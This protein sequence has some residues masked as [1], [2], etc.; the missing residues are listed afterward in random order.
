MGRPPL[1]IRLLGRVEIAR[2][3]ESVHLPPS[4]K[5]LTLLAYLALAPTAVTRT[6]LCDL[7]WDVANDPRGELRWCLSKLRALL[8]DDDR[9]R[10]LTTG[11]ELVRLDLS[12]VFVDVHAVD[13]AMKR[14]SPTELQTLFR[15]DFLEGVDPDGGPELA[16]WL[17][18]A[19]QRYRAARPA[20]AIERPEPEPARR[21]A[22]IVI[23]PFADESPGRPLGHGV[24]DDV[25]TR[26]AKLRA[27]FVI[28]R[29]SAYVLRE[30]GVDAQE[31]GRL[32]GVDYVASGRVRVDNGRIAVRVELAETKRAQIV[33]TDD[34][35]AHASETFD[36]LD[37]IV[38]R[39]VAA[40]AEEVEAEECRRAI[41]KPPASL[42]AWEAYHRGL[43]HM[44]RFTPNDNAEAARFFRRALE[45]DATFARAHSG[46][47]FTH[48]QNVFLDLTPDRDVQLAQTFTT[49]AASLGAD[50]RDPTAH[51]A[52]G[53]AL[54]LRGE[55]TESIGVLR[56][57]FDL[58]P[59]FALGHYML[60]F[61]EA[62]L[63]DPSVAIAESNTSRALSPYDPLQFGMLGLRALAHMRRGEHEEAALWAQRAAARP[64]AHAHI[65]AIAA[66]TLALDGRRDDAR[67]LLAR[68]REG[69][70]GYDV[71]AFLRA[72]RFERDAE[73]LLR[74]AAKTFDFG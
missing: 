67:R 7:L 3:G 48:F 46:L 18:A 70:P 66:S 16:A 21:R 14:G 2:A 20:T 61:V 9:K 53:R 27:L 29:G 31:A 34:I 25:I 50:E 32:L 73:R 63:G 38:D 30:R 49:A 68:I 11:K 8:D 62:Q 19:R 47:S 26:L 6:R 58:S 72:F 40:I 23:M 17:A 54:W 15:G 37:T 57:C 52:M 24:T 4:R 71:D 33:W 51:W 39:I 5:V 43:W 44:Y 60:G 42:D 55:T 10:V 13:E 36:V 59:N 64:N 74:S 41:L 45:L 12:D 22:S 69:L 56:R 28:A 65:V 35:T 1:E